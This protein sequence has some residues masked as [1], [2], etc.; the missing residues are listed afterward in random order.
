[1]KTTV[2]AV[3][4]GLGAVMLST[5]FMRREKKPSY[6]S[7]MKPATYKKLKKRVKQFTK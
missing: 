3:A 7:W 2:S 5:V 1:M 4:T 6:M